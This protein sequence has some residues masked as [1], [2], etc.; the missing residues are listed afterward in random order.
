VLSE[1]R[2]VL[3]FGEFAPSFPLKWD[4]KHSAYPRGKEKCSSRSICSQVNRMRK[5][6]EHSK[7]HRAKNFLSQE[8]LDL[9]NT[10]S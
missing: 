9:S 4:L 8:I 6:K 2:G 5:K 1:W 10:Q 7:K 3:A